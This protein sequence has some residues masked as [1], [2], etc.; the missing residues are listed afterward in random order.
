MIIEL[1][2]NG[3]CVEIMFGKTYLD[4]TVSPCCDSFIF[5]NEEL[6]TIC[7]NVENNVE[8]LKQS[9][10]KDLNAEQ[11]LSASYKKLASMLMGYMLERLGYTIR[12][13]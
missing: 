8:R 5:T 10:I 7:E 6:D 2:K 4:I 9:F 11:N 3:V 12:L 13:A 1:E